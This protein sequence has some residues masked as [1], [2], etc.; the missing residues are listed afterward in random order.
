M[1]SKP[2]VMANTNQRQYNFRDPVLAKDSLSPRYLQD[3]ESSFANA[4]EAGRNSQMMYSV[5]Q[6]RSRD[7]LQGMMS[8]TQ[9]SSRLLNK[10]RNSALGVQSPF[11]DNST[12]GLMLHMPS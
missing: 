11:E 10:K 6:H 1:I 9:G 3:A 4:Q 8:P 2:V 5:D 7:A 12:P